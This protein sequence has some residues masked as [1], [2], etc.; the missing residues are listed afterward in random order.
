MYHITI[1]TSTYLLHTFPIFIWYTILFCPFTVPPY[2][3][4]ASYYD[5]DSL[6]VSFG[7]CLTSIFA[8]FVIFSFLGFMAGEL[9]TTVEKVVDS[10][11]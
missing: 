5:R 7:N 11:K 4:F 3:S 2:Y 8:G 10:G 1:V 9:N 6:I